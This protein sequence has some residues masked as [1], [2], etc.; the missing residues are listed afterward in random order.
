MVNLGP[1][2]GEIHWPDKWTATTVDGKRS[3]QFEDTLLCVV[4]M[5]IS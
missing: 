2:G 1:N 3:A 5:F 4:A